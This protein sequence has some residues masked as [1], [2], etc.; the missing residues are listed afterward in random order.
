MLNDIRRELHL[1]QDESL[2]TNNT[3]NRRLALLNSKIY[4]YQIS[5][6]G[7]DQSKAWRVLE[8]VDNLKNDDVVIVVASTGTNHGAFH[9]ERIIASTRTWMR[10]F[11]HVF[12]VTEDTFETRFALRHCHIKEHSEFTSFT[13]H[14]EAT[15]VLTRTCTSE[16]YN[17]AGI[18]CKVD[19]SINFI[20]NYPEIYSHMKFF[21]QADDDT[22]FRPDQLLRWLASIENSGINHFP[23]V[24]TPGADTSGGV[25]HIDGCKEI[26]TGGWYQPLILNKAGL[27]KVAVGSKDYGI[28]N[29][30]KAFVLSQDVGIGIVAWAYEL[31]HLTIPATEVNGNHEGVKILKPQLMCIHAVRNHNDDKCEGSNWPKKL[32]F[33]QNVVIGCGDIDTPGP[34][35]DAKN[36]WMNMYDVWNYYKVNG[37]DLDFL[38]STKRYVPHLPPAY[39][40]AKVILY[41]NDH[42]NH[43]NAVKTILPV[44]AIIGSDGKYDG[45]KV[46]TRIIPDLYYLEG[47]STTEHSKKY[48]IT[49]KWQKFEL[50]DCA[51]GQANKIQ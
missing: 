3:T 30:C 35:H 49:E 44:D 15:Y 25:W 41:P 45:A 20:T 31:Y 37:Q 22:Y 6:E 17:A 33:K 43:P 51:G 40:E 26:H 5:A 28:T 1:N 34:F 16:Y 7:H 36:K 48:K 9:R 39:V 18:C 50:Q 24:A 21:V 32:R 11:A 23:L 2:I 42:P 29:T 14:N 12:V 19:E 38:G 27:A 13:C 46:V 8:V 47:Y 10:F 4:N